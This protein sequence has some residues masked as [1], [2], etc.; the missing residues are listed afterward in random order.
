M[1]DLSISRAWDET[2]AILARDGRLFVS[3]ALA[4]VALPAAVTGAIR[5]N[6]MADSSTSVWIDLVLIAA[7]LIALAGQLALIRLALGPSITVDGA[8]RHGFLRMP[9]YLLAAILIIAALLVLAI[10]F[11]VVLAALGVPMD[12]SPV[13]RSPA[14]LLVVFLYV[15]VAFFAGVK[16]IMSA[17]AASA[18]PIGAIAIIKRSWE[19]TSGHWWKLFAF[20]LLF[21]I[22]AVIALIA[23]GTAVGLVVT[24]LFGPAEPL[25]AAALVEAL[26]QALINAVVTTLFAVMLARIYV[27]LSG[28]GEVQ[29][30]VPTSGI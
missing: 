12:M 8:I 7:S 21:F 17:P 1:R 15:L 25:S 19:L 22:G 3:V 29:A 6:G 16:M 14:L 10:P 5:P 9:T 30:S 11:G 28:R 4:L 24:I 13:P 26:V 18:E 27:Q 23:A 2:K 20:V